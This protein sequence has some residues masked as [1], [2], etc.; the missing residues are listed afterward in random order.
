[1]IHQHGHVV[2][3][4]VDARELAEEDHDVGVDDGAPAARHGEE[5]HP[6]ELV[7]FSDDVV[8]FL[9]DTG[10]HDEELFFGFEG[11][12]A[13][14]ALPDAIG[15]EGLALVH[16]EAGGFGE[17]KHSKDSVS[18][19]CF[20]GMRSKEGAAAYP[21]PMMVEKTREEPRMKRQLPLTLR[22]M[23]ATT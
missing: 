18:T 3:D 2:H 1:M 15:F 6:G 7:L 9:D 5:V 21:T 20:L 19:F 10:F 17:E 14:D 23:A 22:K 8:F 4:R 11:V 16:E 12:D 13:A